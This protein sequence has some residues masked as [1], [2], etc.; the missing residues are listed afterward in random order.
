[1]NKEIGTYQRLQDN[2]QMENGVLSYLNEAAHGDMKDLIRD[3]G[4]ERKTIPFYNIAEMKKSNDNQ[5]FASDSNFHYLLNAMFTP[6]DMTDHEESF[7]G[8]NE[9]AG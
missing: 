2:P 9:I 7:V 6:V 3:V 5:S 1:M 8:W 4:I